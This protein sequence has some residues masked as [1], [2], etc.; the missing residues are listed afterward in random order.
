MRTPDTITDHY[1]LHFVSWKIISCSG[2]VDVTYFTDRSVTVIKV[3]SIYLYFWPKHSVHTSVFLFDEMN[4]KN[5]K[6]KKIPQEYPPI[7]WYNSVIIW[8]S[9]KHRIKLAS[10]GRWKCS[11]ILWT[12]LSWILVSAV[13][14]VNRKKILGL[15]VWT[16]HIL[17]VSMRVLYGDMHGVWLTDESRCEYE[18]FLVSLLTLQQI[19]DLSGVYLSLCSWPHHNWC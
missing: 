19:G 18:W 10:T 5:N 16:L 8:L 12:F 7:F 17:P 15:S 9:F 13:N 6:K 2:S 11:M 3:Y 14:T 1:I 4:N